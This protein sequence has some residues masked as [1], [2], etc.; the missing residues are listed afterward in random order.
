MTAI[1]L[2]GMKA[3]A[4]GTST[5]PHA[6]KTPQHADWRLGYAMMEEQIQQALANAESMLSGIQDINRFRH[7]VKRP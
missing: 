4:T 7:P 1:Q 3:R 6:P 5:N 2:E